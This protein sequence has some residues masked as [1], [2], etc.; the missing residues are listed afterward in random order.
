MLHQL[1][2][3]FLVKELTFQQWTFW[4]LMLS[5]ANAVLSNLLELAFPFFIFKGIISFFFFPVLIPYLQYRLSLVG[6]HITPSN[7]VHVHSFPTGPCK[8]HLFRTLTFWVMHHLVQPCAGVQ[9]Q[10]LPEGH[11]Q[12]AGYFPPS[13]KQQNKAEAAHHVWGFLDSVVYIWTQNVVTQEL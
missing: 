10:H 1:N 3:L 7:A 5:R 12:A 4:L 13:V 11:Q 6:L 8:G 9:K 2:S